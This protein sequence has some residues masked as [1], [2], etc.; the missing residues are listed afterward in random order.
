[1]SF[2]WIISLYPPDIPK[3]EA[4]GSPFYRRENWAFQKGSTWLQSLYRMPFVHHLTSSWPCH[5]RQPR[6]PLHLTC[7]SLASCGYV[8]MVTLHGSTLRQWEQEQVGKICC[9]WLTVLT[10]IPSDFSEGPVWSNQSPAA[11]KALLYWIFLLPCSLSCPSLGA[12]HSPVNYPT[13]PS[14]S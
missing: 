7:F 9:P 8:G 10:H 1:M 14:S 4:L 2:T 11:V 5:W 12:S 6:L 13:H 3:R